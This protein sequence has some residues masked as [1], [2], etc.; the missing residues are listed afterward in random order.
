LSLWTILALYHFVRGNR[1]WYFL[2]ATCMVLT[3]ESGTIVIVSILLYQA[4]CL[5]ANKIIWKSLKLFLQDSMFAFLPI[6]SFLIFL[7]IQHYQR[8]YYFFPEHISLLNFNWNDFQYRLQFCYN[9]TFELQGRIFFTWSFLIAFALFYKPIP[10]FIRFFIAIG[11]MM[12]VRIFFKHGILSDWQVNLFI[13]LFAAV[14]YYFMH[15][16]YANEGK[17]SNKMLAS[18]FI[19][20]IL[21]L[22]FCAVNV[23]TNR[24]LFLFIPLMIV[25]F[26]YYVKESLR[27]F[28]FLPYVWG[29]LLMSVILYGIFFHYKDNGLG[30]DSPNYVQGVKLEKNIIGYLEQQNLQKDTIDCAF[31]VN[32][33]LKNKDM[34]YLS[35]A[36]FTHIVGKIYMKPKYVVYTN[37]DYDSLWEKGS[38]TLAH[39]HIIKKFEYGAA[40]GKIFE[41]NF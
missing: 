6:F 24:Y 18:I 33:A 4:I 16:K 17:Y 21:Y 28:A 15:I 25:Y 20:G 35:G 2:F 34:G 9:Y 36:S 1:Y 29:T 13:G 10:K 37:V 7:G 39:F 26:S 23:F 3:K 12:C 40:N 31:T 27:Y 11:L 38:D 30:D 8:G 14:F 32:A 5:F 19:I 41:R 22:I